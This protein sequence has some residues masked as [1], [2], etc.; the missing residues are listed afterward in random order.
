MAKSAITNDPNEARDKALESPLYKIVRSSWC[1]FDEKITS[2]V[3]NLNEEDIVR[4]V[5]WSLENIKGG[6]DNPEA[7]IH[8]LRRNVV[9]LFREK[10]YSEG[11]VLLL[12]N[13]ICAYAI[14]CL[15]CAFL[16]SYRNDIYRL[17]TIAEKTIIKEQKQNVSEIKEIIKKIV[18]QSK[19]SSELGEWCT[20][21][22]L[23]D[24]YLTEEDAEWAES[25]S[26]TNVDADNKTEPHTFE[27]TV[28]VWVK[29][30]ES[31]ITSLYK[32]KKYLID[33]IKDL[34][35]SYVQAINKDTK[36]NR[37]GFLRENIFWPKTPW[38]RDST[39]LPSEAIRD[40]FNDTGFTSQTVSKARK[41]K[42]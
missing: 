37:T 10:K 13:A 27:M 6:K 30:Y 42:K 8:K 34:R 39:L 1:Y 38:L 35:A 29:R 16:H 11:A 14:V 23:N 15:D 28:D 36:F 26:E 17:C 5:I 32:D 31:K 40:L 21:H 3:D 20:E 19:L 18:L 2:S 24:V 9:A 12:S 41:Q 4:F 7:N 33:K 25:L 22:L